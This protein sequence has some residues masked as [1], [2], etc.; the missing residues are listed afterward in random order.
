YIE[1]PQSQADQ[2][3]IEWQRRQTLKNAERFINEELKAFEDKAL[4]AQERALAREKML[5]EQVLEQLQPHLPALTAFARALAALDVLCAFAERAS[6]L[7]WCAPE[8]VAEPCI[9]ITGGRHPVVQESLKAGSGAPFRKT[10]APFCWIWRSANA[11]APALRACACN[12][13]ACTVFIL[14]C[15]KARPTRYRLNGSGARR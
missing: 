14:K 2:V 3:P 10:A 11:R 13:T 7:Q 15:R 9:E 8:F 1:V 4:S 6:T 5:Y 12:T